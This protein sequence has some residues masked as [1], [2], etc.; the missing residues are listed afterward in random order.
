[1]AAHGAG[2]L[3]EAEA[4]YRRLLQKW[5]EDAE[6]LHLMG[7]CLHQRGWH[8]DGLVLIERAVAA[9]PGSLPYG[10]N[11]A[12]VLRALGRLSDAETELR[13]VL[14]LDGGDV[15]ALAN[16]GSLLMETGGI[17]EAESLLRRAITADPWFVP[18]RAAL[19]KLLVD[20]DAWDDVLEVTAMSDGG[21]ASD[22]TVLVNRASALGRLGR[23]LEAVETLDAADP[24]SAAVHNNLGNLLRDLGNWPSAQAH[25]RRAL[26]LEPGLFVAH[27]NVMFTMLFD[28]A[29]TGGAMLAEGRRW[30]ATRALALGA[31][32]LARDPDKR[33]RLGYVSPDFKEH[34][35]AYFSE[36]LLR[37]HDRS[38]VEVICYSGTAR[39]DKTTERLRSLADGWVDIHRMGD[40][41]LAERI[42]ADGID[43]LI[44]LAGHTQGNRLLAMSERPAPVQVSAVLGYGGSTG[45]SWMDWVLT[46]GVLTPP[47]FEDQFSERVMRLE[48]SFGAFLPRTDWPEVAPAPTGP[49][50]LGCFSDPSRV[51]GAQVELWRSVLDAVPG[52]RLLFKHGTYD[53]PKM[54]A[55]W[56]G[57]FG[58][59]ADRA[60]FEGVKGGWGA[61]MGVYGRV[62]L[63]LDTWP[64]SGATSALIPLWMGVP[65]VTLSGGHAGQRFGTAVVTAA[66]LPEL[67][68]ATPRDYV[69]LVA[70][71]ANDRE[72]LAELRR[73]LR[74]RLRESPLLDGPGH[75]RAVEK[76]LRTIWRDACANT[77]GDRK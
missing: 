31:R 27:S 64:V 23:R 58:L 16:L 1:M 25:Y 77:G 44:D 24:A 57:L 29:T 2:R 26:E 39:P 6:L 41:T 63:V 32:P 52:S 62:R 3:A 8:A 71:L 21:I 67:S 35:V 11:R 68:A 54:A 75:A 47:G 50:V 12:Q 49:P 61:H 69:R 19:S 40:R 66:G 43:I 56:R 45:L 46:D 53:D 59:V 48:G 55:Y 10:V 9:A 5:P 15:I 30:E 60:D 4:I 13:R 72:R 14:R 18:A 74:D 38:A 28:P 33:L 34:A 76:A 37:G 42:R 36:P 7:V 22:T 17:V 51:D 65:V 70:E 73:S 20:A